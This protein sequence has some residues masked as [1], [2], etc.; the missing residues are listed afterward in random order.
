MDNNSIF[1][2]SP[3]DSN[4]NKVYPENKGIILINAF[5]DMKVIYGREHT[6]MM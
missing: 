3:V 1:E 2:D 6:M 4:I 5:G